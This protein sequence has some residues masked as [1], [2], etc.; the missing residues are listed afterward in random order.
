MRLSLGFVL[1][2]IVVVVAVRPCRAP[3]V[4]QVTLRWFARDV[5]IGR[6]KPIEA[7]P[8][9]RRAPPAGCRARRTAPR[10]RSLRERERFRTLGA[11]GCADGATVPLNVSAAAQ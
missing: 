9:S 1:P 6:E 4:D 2:L 11:W 10:R 7:S 5:T 8:T 3:L